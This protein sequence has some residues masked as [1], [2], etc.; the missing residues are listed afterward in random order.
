MPLRAAATGKNIDSP[1]FRRQR[2]QRRPGAALS[3]QG[4]AGHDQARAGTT[5]KVKVW[6]VQGY[7]GPV[8]VDLRNLGATSIV[9]GHD[10]RR[11]KHRR[12]HA[13]RSARRPSRS[14][15]QQAVSRPSASRSPRRIARSRR[16][17][18]R[19]KWVE[20]ER[21]SR[22]CVRTPRVWLAAK[23]N[24]GEPPCPQLQEMDRLPRR[25]GH[26]E[27]PAFA[28]VLPRATSLA[29]IA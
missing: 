27:S 1:R 10:R 25:T 19:Y 8:A 2:R 17:K 9:E 16:R 23:P 20:N 13:D 12:D 28:K 29:S 22:L 24:K 26:R 11:R 15:A 21:R 5:A 14:H 18:S 4:R 3:A 6:A 7:A